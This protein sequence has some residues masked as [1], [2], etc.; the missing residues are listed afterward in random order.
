MPEILLF[1]KPGCQKCDYVK[2]HLPAGIK[3]NY[4]DT[5]TA[6]GLAEAAYYEI[7]GK[8]TPILVVDDQVTEG[9]IAIMNRLNELAD[10]GQ[11]A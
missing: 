10:N 1:T 11:S 9:A 3:I 8:H 6:D 4:V 7:L 2:E 5:S